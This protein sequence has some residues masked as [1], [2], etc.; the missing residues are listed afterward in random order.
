MSIKI[1]PA[2]V[3]FAL[4]SFIGLL[5]I[6]NVIAWG[7]RLGTGHG[8]LMGLIPMFDFNRELNIPTLYSSFALLF[9]A[10][11]LALIALKQRAA[12]LGWLAWAGLALIFAFLSLD[13][14][15]SIHEQLTTPVRESLGSSGGLYYAWVIPY[16]VGFLFLSLLYLNFFLRLPFRFKRLFF[17]SA[18]IFVSGA[19][20]FEMLGGWRAEGHG[21]EDLI[22][23]IL[24]TIEELGEM[25]GVVAFIYTL[26]SYIVY[27]F[28]GLNLSLRDRLEGPGEKGMGEAVP[29]GA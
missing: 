10:V 21:E 14:V 1:S 7:I 2:K 5:A 19:I 11:L 16:L 15:G 6:A 25:V 23:C 3:L 8:N 27:Q 12:N 28:G 20:G 24:Y 17:I 9:C 13:E 18:F 22:Y 26:L 29:K 4:L